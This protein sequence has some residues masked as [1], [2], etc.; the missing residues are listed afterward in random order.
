MCRVHFEM[1]LRVWDESGSH[2]GDASIDKRGGAEP[3]GSAPPS[4]R[5][6]GPPAHSSPLK[7]ATPSSRPARRMRTSDRLMI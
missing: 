4:T 1:C 3:L 7:S 5:P 6:S 2:E